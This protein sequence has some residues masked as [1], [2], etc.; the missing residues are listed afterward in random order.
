V[1]RPRRQSS[2]GQPS[3]PTELCDVIELCEVTELCEFWEMRE[4]WE[5]CEA[6]ELWELR[7]DVKEAALS[8]L[9]DLVR[10]LQPLLLAAST[11]SSRESL[12]ASGSRDKPPSRDLAEELEEDEMEDPFSIAE[13][14]SILW[15]LLNTLRP[16][17]L[18]I[19]LEAL[20]LKDSS[21]SDS[22]SP[23]LLEALRLLGSLGEEP[24][25]LDAL[26]LRGSDTKESVS[27]HR[28]LSQ[29]SS[30][31]ES[32]EKSTS[33]FSGSNLRVVLSLNEGRW[34]LEGLKSPLPSAFR[35]L[36][37]FRWL[38]ETFLVSGN[39]RLLILLKLLSIDTAMAFSNVAAKSVSGEDSKVFVGVFKS[40]EDL[41]SPEL[42]KSP[43]RF[44][45]PKPSL[46]TS[47]VQEAI[48]PC[49]LCTE[50][51]EDCI[52]VH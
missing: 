3:E 32:H 35:R 14:S 28:L 51:S 33:W 13:S 8:I 52:L 41:P 39:F 1:V 36:V 6:S 42:V 11:A 37:S 49:T 38:L 10:F 15:F 4:R 21:A 30:R 9:S 23:M 31:A 27:Q 19:P 34:D 40:V 48:T 25:P 16:S 12:L 2:Q 46:E 17:R 43:P 29:S 50:T 20:R 26:R 44:L 47:L 5:F 22:V 45:A 7:E 18:P 24:I